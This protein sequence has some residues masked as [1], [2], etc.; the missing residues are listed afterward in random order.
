MLFFSV[1]L[2][3][4][5]SGLSKS[6]TNYEIPRSSDAKLSSAVRPTND[7]T[8]HESSQGDDNPE[9]IETLFIPE[10]P[11]ENERILLY[12]RR[13]FQPVEE[14]IDSFDRQVPKDLERHA[15]DN[16][17]GEDR[18][19]KLEDVRGRNSRP[20]EREEDGEKY[21]QRN[22]EGG[23]SP[24]TTTESNRKDE[25]ISMERKNYDAGY[26]GKG[27][28]DEKDLLEAANFGLDAMR[29]LYNVKEPMLY[30]MGEFSYSFFQVTI[31]SV[32]ILAMK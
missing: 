11:S 18:F 29:D 32:H 23:V 30:S 1:L 26:N 6:V 28:P 21:L 4:L 5:F 17:N 7:S 15:I 8:L 25:V 13:L 31:V 24:R 10:D 16:E 22:P 27:E 14:S 19:S 12:V 2:V 3:L 20:S 9:P